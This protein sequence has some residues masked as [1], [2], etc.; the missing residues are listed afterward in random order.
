MK[1]NEKSCLVSTAWLA[2]HLD[3]EGLCIFDCSG[4]LGADYANRGREEH[5]DKHH[6]P[7]AAY[8]DVAN[9]KGIISNPDAA[10][11]F[12]WPTQAQFETAMGRIGVGNQSR[13][14]LYAAPS[15]GVPGSGVYWATRAWWLMHH[16][17]VD[18]AILDGGWQKWVAEGRPVSSEP[19]T[20]PAATFKA[21][22]SWKR[23]LALKQDVL[24]AINSEGSQIVDCLSPESYRGEIDK[25]YGAFGSRKGH[26]TGA[27]NVHFQGLLDLDSGCFLQPDQLRKRFDSGKVD[28]GGHIITYC[29][30]GVGATVDGFALKMLGHDDIALYDGS[31]MEWANDATL[32]MTD[33]TQP[34]GK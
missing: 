8:L 10:L 15:P 25:I 2:G 18:C 31:M 30:G 22:P 3:D 1:S 23:G 21:D 12:T 29:G 11:P 20:Y 14:I 27:K 6:I 28:L 34:G 9:P 16:F 26:I 33:L 17:G 19:H 7:G 4:I 5:Y 13:V 24:A 32:P